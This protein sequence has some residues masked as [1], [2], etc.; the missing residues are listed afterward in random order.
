ML[1]QVAGINVT[2]ILKVGTC[3]KWTFMFQT[4]KADQKNFENFKIFELDSEKTKKS[5]LMS[6]KLSGL[7]KLSFETGL[8]VT[9]WKFREH[10]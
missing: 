10:S 6:P 7:K 8:K 3:F 5:T 2:L 1:F 9:V 4:I